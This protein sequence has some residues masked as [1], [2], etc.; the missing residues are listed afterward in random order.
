MIAFELASGEEF[1]KS[2]VADSQNTLSL[3]WANGQR[4]YGLRGRN[5][6]FDLWA[7]GFALRTHVLRPA[8]CAG[9]F[10]TSLFG[11]LENPAQE[12][13]AGFEFRRPHL[14]AYHQ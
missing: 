13:L 14:A 11:E 5:E 7:Y 3:T 6:P 8:I 10:K 1:I 12:I 9:H 2:G 4:L